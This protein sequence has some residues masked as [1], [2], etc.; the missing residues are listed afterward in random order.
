MIYSRR[1]REPGS[2]RLSDQQRQLL[3]ETA[4]A[5][6]L[7]LQLSAVL[8]SVVLG[9]LFAGLLLDRVAGTAPLGILCLMVLGTTAGTILVYRIVVAT[10]PAP[11]PT[12]PEGKAGD[13]PP[14]PPDD[15]QGRDAI[16]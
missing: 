3:R 5:M 12:P 2:P 10:L 8:V 14:A 13:S 11:P 1:S 9:C 6:G 15:G 4:K 16:S 7:A